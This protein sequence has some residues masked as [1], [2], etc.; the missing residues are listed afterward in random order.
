MEENIQA[1]IRD[2][3]TGRKVARIALNGYS[4]LVD[5]LTG[6]S[7][8]L[9]SFHV[10]AGDLHPQWRSAT[11]LLICVG[12]GQALPARVAALPVEAGGAGL[13]EFLLPAA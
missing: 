2:A 8:A 11:T 10:I 7:R 3:T 13:I 12:N 4:A 1:T 6:G 9:R 5:N